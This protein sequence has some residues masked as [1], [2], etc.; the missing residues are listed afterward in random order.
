MVS[1]ADYAKL[2]IEEYNQRLKSWGDS[3]TWGLNQFKMLEDLI[4][5]VTHV[6]INANTLKRFFQQR[7][8]NPQLATKNALCV[9]LGYSGYSEFVIKHTISADKPEVSDERVPKD[10]PVEPGT[11]VGSGAGDRQKPSPK[12]PAWTLAVVIALVVIVLGIVGMGPMKRRY[13]EHLFS[14]IRFEA[15]A[16]KGASPMTVRFDYEIPSQLFDS[17]RVVYEESNGDVISKPLQS[18][19]HAIYMTY[20]YDGRNICHLKYGNRTL[21]TISVE[22]RTPGWSVYVWDDRQNSFGTVPFEK[23]K[24]AEGYISLP[25]EDVPLKIESDKLFVSYTYYEE[26]LIDGDNFILEAKV[27]N[28]MSDNGISCFD[29]MMYLFSNTRMHGFCIN[30]DC[31]SFVKFVA[32]ENT[33]RGDQYDFK[34]YDFDLSDWRVMRMEVRDKQVS[35]SL[36]GVPVISMSYQE[37]IGMANE[38]TLRFKGCGAV[39]YVR[40]LTLDG[41]EMYATDFR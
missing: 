30:Q 5:E 12:Y 26:N 10:Q 40:L 21:K 24:T 25:K 4:A 14:Q 36:D 31:P 16:L 22:T 19:S 1:D 41:E 37:S 13:K 8:S 6:R 18:D 27:R 32:G 28:S 39:D 15:S 29:A 9:F 17:I 23:A 38:L 7:T 35:F 20:I 34:G 11:T 2:I 3:D 33:I